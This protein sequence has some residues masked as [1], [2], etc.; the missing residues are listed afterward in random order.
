[1]TTDQPFHADVLVVH[2]S[3]SGGTAGIAVTVA[4]A[5]R[6]TG[7]AVDVAT[8]ADAAGDGTVAG[9][10]AVVLGSA[11]YA[12]RWRR[13]A[14]RFLRRHRVLLR[15]RPVWL[16]QSGPCGPNAARDAERGVAEPTALRRL[17]EDLEIGPPVTFGGV[18]DPETAR[19]FVARRMAR[20]RLAGD[21]RDPERIRAWAMSIAAAVPPLHRT[22]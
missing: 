20:G 15:E 2:A 11:L 16:F 17:R 7:L 1:M 8:A 14:L 12:G 22:S 5:L 10:R 6:D 21:Y 18:L 4:E 3:K 19:G 13:D 9:Y